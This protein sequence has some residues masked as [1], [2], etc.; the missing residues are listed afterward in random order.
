M[1][2]VITL[3]SGENDFELTKKLAQLRAGFE[4]TAERFDAADLTREQLADIFAGQTLFALKRMIILDMP[5]AN[6]DL[7][8]N[9]AAWAERLSGDTLLVFVEPKPDKRTSTYKWLKKNADVQEFQPLDERDVRGLAKWV[10]EY[11][12]ETGLRLTGH[13]AQRLAS[14][15]GSNQWELAHAV[16]KLALVDEVTDEWIDNVVQAS[17]SENVF[18][19]FETVLNDDVARLHDM[20]A[21]LRQSEDPYRILGL[22]N[23]QALQLTALVYGDGNVSKVASD[24]GASSSYPFQKLASFAVRLGKSQVRDMIALLADA[25]IRLKSSDADPWVVLESTLVRIASLK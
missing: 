25:D 15:A 8:Q 10:E 18:A 5:S 20:L 3:L 17:P 11:A 14:M 23:S 16:D 2:R 24:T 19:L 6:G 1:V 22:I 21:A 13:Q 7:W 12:R 4:G 9:I